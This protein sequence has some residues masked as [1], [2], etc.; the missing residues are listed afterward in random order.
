[1]P[2]EPFPGRGDASN[3]LLFLKSLLPGSFGNEGRNS[4]GME[5]MRSP[6]PE[7][8]SGACGPWCQGCLASLQHPLSYQEKGCPAWAWAASLAEACALALPLALAFSLALPH[9][10]QHAQLA[11]ARVVPAFPGAQPYHAMA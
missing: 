4:F 1:M 8:Q 11:L 9:V 2:Q 3:E 7:L 5:E 10:G 6:M